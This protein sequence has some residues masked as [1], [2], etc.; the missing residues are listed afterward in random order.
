MSST[1]QL[2]EGWREL[3]EQKQDLS[4]FFQDSEQ[5]L[6]SLCRRPAELE[7]KIAQNVLAQ[8]EVGS[9]MTPADPAEFCC[10]TELLL[11]PQDCCLQLRSKQ[12]ILT[13]MTES[14][15][16]L[17]GDQS[18]SEHADL[19]RLSRSWMDLC[20]QAEELQTQKEEDLR[21]AGE[22][23]ACIAA[24]EALFEQVSGAWDS[25]ARSV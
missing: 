2:S 11:F 14:V 1:Q 25:L 19:E 8:A 5:Q 16:R 18:S 6:L 9:V 22:Y 24:V 4:S 15:S 20:H 17:S 23:H 7:L 13:R 21:R 12:S 10:L 3:K